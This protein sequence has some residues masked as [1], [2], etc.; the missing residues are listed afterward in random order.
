MSV[1][2]QGEGRK[3]GRGK[4]GILVELDVSFPSLSSLSR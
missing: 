2:P 4:E 1:S 3:C